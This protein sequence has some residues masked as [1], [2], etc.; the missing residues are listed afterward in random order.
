MSDRNATPATRRRWAHELL[1]VH[2]D[3]VRSGI[4]KVI[5]SLELGLFLSRLAVMLAS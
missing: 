1:L 5:L 2:L 3:S 4:R